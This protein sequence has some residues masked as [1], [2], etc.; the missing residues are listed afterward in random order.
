EKIKPAFKLPD[1]DNTYDISQVKEAQKQMLPPTYADKFD[2]EKII[3]DQIS[4]VSISVVYDYT[5]SL[6]L[7]FMEPLSIT[8]NLIDNYFK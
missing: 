6:K 1:D 8:I 4:K 5:G 7:V 2:M 3:S